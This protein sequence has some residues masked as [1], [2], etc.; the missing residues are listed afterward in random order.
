[1]RLLAAAVGLFSAGCGA[2]ADSTKD[3]GVS[4]LGAS[5]EVDEGVRDV[6]G[7]ADARPGDMRPPPD[8]T[9]V[10]G[11]ARLADTGLYSDFANRAFVPDVIRYVPRYQLWSDGAEKE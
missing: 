3:S 1:M 4:E 5:I 2:T 8:L 11:P 6:D 7:G 9:P 10:I